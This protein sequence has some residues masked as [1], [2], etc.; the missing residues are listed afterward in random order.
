MFEVEN[1]MNFL[2]IGINVILSSIVVVVFVVIL[3]LV[4]LFG[5]IF[6]CVSFYSFLYF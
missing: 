4:M 5:N 6:V 3:I 2:L 1:V